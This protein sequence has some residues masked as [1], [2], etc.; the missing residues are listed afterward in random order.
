MP[1][2]SNRYIAMSDEYTIYSSMF[3]PQ[4][5]SETLQ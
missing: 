1:V 5:I 2:Q 4:I 3:N